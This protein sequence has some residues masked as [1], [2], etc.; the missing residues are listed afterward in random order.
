M[1]D[2]RNNWMKEGFSESLQSTVEEDYKKAVE[3]DPKGPSVVQQIINFDIIDGFKEFLGNKLLID[4]KDGKIKEIEVAR[5]VGFDDPWIYTHSDTD[6]HC[7][8]YQ[9]IVSKLNFIPKKCMNCWKVVARPRNLKETFIMLRMQRDMVAQD[10]TCWCKIGAEFRPWVFGNW[11]AY[12]YNNSRA[13]GE[14]KWKWVRDMTDKYLDPKV[15]VI[16]KR[17]CTE[18]EREFGPSS[19]WDKKFG[20]QNL[21]VKAWEKILDEACVE[22]DE[23]VKSQPPVVQKHVMA[24]WI[25]FAWDRADETVI[26]LNNGN[27]LLPPLEFYHHVLQREYKLKKMQNK[28]KDTVTSKRGEGVD[29][30]DAEKTAC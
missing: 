2:T 4:P 29:E 8:Q 21:L 6:R 25:A 26:E 14:K 16:L 28:M 19:G 24:K 1:S 7:H 18:F 11:G 23:A 22:L 27:P 13:D 9:R 30:R 15:P 20:P 10:D 3:E 12:F 5:T 17:G